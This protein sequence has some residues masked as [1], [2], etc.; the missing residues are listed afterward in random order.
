[1]KEKE[2]DLEKENIA[3][4]IQASYS[5]DARP[6]PQTGERISRILLIH[7]QKRLAIVQFPD[8]AVGVMGI[9]LILVAVYVTLQLM[10]GKSYATHP[11]FL[12]MIIW[13]VLNLLALPLASVVIVM[14]RQH[15]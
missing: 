8:I 10:L 13:L 5:S 9:I 7:S 1:M 12:L 2:C 15:E 3:H 6:H 14:R 4:L 11:T